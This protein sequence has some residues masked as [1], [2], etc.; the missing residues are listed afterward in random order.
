MPGDNRRLPPHLNRMP[1]GF[2]R[3]R[4]GQWDGNIH[5]PRE[6]HQANSIFNSLPPAAALPPAMHR[7]TEHSFLTD[8]S[9]PL[10][11]YREGG[12]KKI[13]TADLAVCRI[14]DWL[15]KDE[16][17]RRARQGLEAA[18]QY[19]REAEAIDM[20]PFHVWQS[21][22]NGL[23]M[24][25]LS[26]AVYLNWDHTHFFDDATPGQ[27]WAPKKLQRPVEIERIAILLNGSFMSARMQHPLSQTATKDEAGD[28]F[29]ATLVHQMVH[30]WF[31]RACGQQKKGGDSDQR[32]KHGEGFWKIMYAIA[33]ASRS[34]DALYGP[35][36]TPFADILLRVHKPLDESGEGNHVPRHLQRYL[37]EEMYDNSLCSTH[38]ATIVSK[39][40][41]DAWFKKISGPA[42]DA[43]TNDIYDFDGDTLES[44]TYPRHEKG[45]PSSYIEIVWEKKAFAYKRKGLEKDFESLK[46]KFSDGRRV[47]SLPRGVDALTFRILD[48]FLKSGADYRP[49]LAPLPAAGIP[50]LSG[51][52]RRDEACKNKTAGLW[53]DVRAFKLGTAIQFP[54][55][56]NH[57][58]ARLNTIR[59]MRFDPLSALAE[60]YSAPSSLTLVAPTL[61]QKGIVPTTAL[62][63][64]VPADELRSWARAFMLATHP[65]S[66]NGGFYA[67]NLFVMER[68][69][70]GAGV[71][72]LLASSM[73]AELEQDYG[74]VLT[75]LW[76]KTPRSMFPVG[77]VFGAG[78]A[79][80]G[81]RTPVDQRG[82]AGSG[83]RAPTANG[84]GG[85]IR[86]EVDWQRRR[87]ELLDGDRIGGLTA[88]ETE[89]LRER[90]RARGR[91]HDREIFE[92]VRTGTR[93]RSVDGLL[94]ESVEE[95][96]F[97][98]RRQAE[99]ARDIY[100]GV[101]SRLPPDVRFREF[102]DDSS[103]SD[104]DDPRFRRRR[105][106][107]N[108]GGGVNG[109]GPGNARARGPGEVVPF[110]GGPR[111]G[112]GAGPA[113]AS[114]L[115]N[116][117]APDRR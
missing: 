88:T 34:S 46:Q 53:H 16:G 6:N 42:R 83:V 111:G 68:H 71:Q 31:M 33:D 22:D 94:R 43:T 79:V 41:A 26:A 4:P 103:S 52:F 85:A 86:D 107:N 81:T 21:L 62:D 17:K 57:A 63:T 47:L 64:G 50:L 75:A 3:A 14:V 91:A 97:R 45:S 73:S 49:T 100:G 96:A 38:V 84:A 25:R 48:S 80:L 39:I 18:R 93:H 115:Y 13:L 44:K 9:A 10:P 95:A 15:Q 101:S 87:R 65:G 82:L 19:V 99:A 70:G 35:E 28:E 56:S 36:V 30:A 54:E 72:G 89:L 40:D 110:A 20:I 102:E 7:D 1:P 117:W 27:T 61:A 92:R 2:G 105:W 24:G 90:Q 66:A 29:L 108:R 77:G 11:E 98:I 60:I 78:G 8:A 109:P 74:V 69:C 51:P 32:L 113:Q 116:P 55:L 37:A 5:Q 114:D 76:E 106:P 23:F 67:S 59:T 112:D 12:D 58:L 104:D